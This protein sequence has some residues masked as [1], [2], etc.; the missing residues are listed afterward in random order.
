LP[1]VSSLFASL[2]PIQQYSAVGL[3]H[4]QTFTQRCEN[5]CLL[6]AEQVPKGK[7]YYIIVIIIVINRYH[8]F[9]FS[10]KYS[11]HFIPYSAR[12]RRAKHG[13]AIPVR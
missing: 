12:I 10:Y 2:Q 13:F 8:L 6:G 4:H 11:D 9:H 1:T 5:C 7:W 3:E